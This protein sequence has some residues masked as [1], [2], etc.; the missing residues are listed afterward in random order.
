MFGVAYWHR[1]YRAIKAMLHWMVWTA[2]LSE[3]SGPDEMSVDEMKRSGK[4]LAQRIIE[5]VAEPSSDTLP[6]MP[7]FL[8]TMQVNG[9]SQI[10]FREAVV[11]AS[12]NSFERDRV[13]QTR[14]KS[15][16]VMLRLL[17]NHK[18]YKAVLTI[19]HYQN[20]QVSSP[21]EAKSA[22]RLWETLQRFIDP[23]RKISHE[24]TIHRRMRLSMTL[25]SRVLRELSDARPITRIL[26]PRETYDRML[27]E[28]SSCQLF[29]V[30]FIEKSK[31]KDKPLYF[32]V[33]ERSGSRLTNTAN[34]IPVRESFD[35]KQLTEEFLVSNG[36]IRIFCHPDYATFVAASLSAERLEQILLEAAESLL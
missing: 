2:V 35:Q 29:L 23:R 18:W 11:L 30:D 34:P 22:K 25:Q 12:I 1:S 3:H 17:T 6:V 19:D 4:E 13:S 7:G 5:D 14:D 27:T 26:N 28:A 36:A 15:S 33:A 9:L 32:L 31:S 16:D 10:P 8:E 24:A 21:D 20:L